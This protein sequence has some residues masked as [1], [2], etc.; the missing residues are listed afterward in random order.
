M[1]TAGVLPACPTYNTGE[2]SNENFVDRYAELVTTG[3]DVDNKSQLCE[4]QLLP[5]HMPEASETN[6]G[7]Y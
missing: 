3:A 4:R 5:S 2:I 7:R 1:K 6:V